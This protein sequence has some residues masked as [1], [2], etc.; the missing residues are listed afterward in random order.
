MSEPLITIKEY[1]LNLLSEKLERLHGFFVLG[2]VAETI[3][4]SLDL[5]PDDADKWIY[6]TKQDEKNL[7]ENNWIFLGFSS[8]PEGLIIRD[9]AEKMKILVD[10]DGSKENR[11]K[12]IFPNGNE[13]AFEFE[14]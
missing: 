3:T 13:D 10:W 11:L 5:I 2:G 1:K 9:E 8:L 4:N 6:W 14:G 7:Y 12:L